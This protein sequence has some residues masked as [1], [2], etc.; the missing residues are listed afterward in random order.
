MIAGRKVGLQLLR[1]AGAAPTSAPCWG[2][3]AANGSFCLVIPGRRPLVAAFLTNRTGS[4]DAAQRV[5]RALADVA[6]SGEVASPDRRRG[7][8]DSRLATM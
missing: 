2:H 1:P 6:A 8:A 4:A 5:L 7:R 3:T